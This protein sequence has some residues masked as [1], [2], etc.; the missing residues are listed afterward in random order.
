MPVGHGLPCRVDGL[1][2][3]HA[4][5][6]ALRMLVRERVEAAEPVRAWLGI[7]AAHGCSS[8]SA[9]MVGHGHGTE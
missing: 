4:D 9:R 3:A 8:S 7:V 2:A 5:A 6:A 1:P